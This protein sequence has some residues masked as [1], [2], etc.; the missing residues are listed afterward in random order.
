MTVRKSIRSARLRARPGGRRA[1]THPVRPTAGKRFISQL[2]PLQL[3]ASEYDLLSQAV[4]LALRLKVVHGS[5]LQMRQGLLLSRCGQHDDMTEYLR[6]A[7]CNP[8]AALARVSEKIAE[9][10]GGRGILEPPP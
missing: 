4:M 9:R 10:L 7:V 8:L 1:Q 5:T 6:V 2:P 3:D